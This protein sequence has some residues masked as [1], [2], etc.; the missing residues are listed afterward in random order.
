MFK[1]IFPFL[2]RPDIEFA[3]GMCVVH[4]FLCSLFALG[5]SVLMSLRQRLRVVRHIM[6]KGARRASSWD[7]TAS[8]RA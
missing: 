3:L 8:A 6:Q 2:K 4:F 1:S 7:G 5:R